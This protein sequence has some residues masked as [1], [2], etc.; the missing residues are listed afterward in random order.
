MRIEKTRRL[1]YRFC[2]I[3][4]ML[5]IFSF[6]NQ[7]GKVSSKVSNAVANTLQNEQ[8]SEN[9][10]VSSQPLFA[11]LSLRKYAHIILYFFLGLFAILS[12]QDNRRKWYINFLIAFA[13]C[14]LYSCSDE[15][16]QAFVQG[17]EKSLRSF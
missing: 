4:M 9:V 2:L 8:K 11:G 10:A 6:S 16:H 17:R 13:I 7:P 12:V 3:F 14:F 1:F 5:I 15:F